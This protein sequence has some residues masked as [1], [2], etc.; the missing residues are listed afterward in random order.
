[1]RKHHSLAA[2]I[3][4]DP[5]NAF[6]IGAIVRHQNLA[7]FGNESSERRLDRKGPAA[8]QGNADVIG[9]RMQDGQ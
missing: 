4:E 8:L 5:R 2:L 1:M 6:A 3:L 9:L 7:V